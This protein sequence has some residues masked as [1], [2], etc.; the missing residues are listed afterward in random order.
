MSTGCAHKTMTRIQFGVVWYC[1]SG[2]L[3]SRGELW[4]A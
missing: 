2:G 4:A 3:A 1:S